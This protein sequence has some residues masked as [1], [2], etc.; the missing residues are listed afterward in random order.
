MTPPPGSNDA[1]EVNDAS[2]SVPDGDEPLE[3]GATRFWT[4][5]KKAYMDVFPKIGRA[6]L[7][8]QRMLVHSG[9]PVTRGTKYTM[10]SDFMFEKR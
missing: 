9:E 1:S 3:G 8:Q 2:R 6:L 10:R 5:N 7:F 4:P